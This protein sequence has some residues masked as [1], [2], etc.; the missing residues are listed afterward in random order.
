[1]FLVLLLAP[2]L[3]PPVAVRDIPANPGLGFHWPYLLVTPSQPVRP[4]IRLMG[5]KAIVRSSSQ[6]GFQQLRLPYLVP[7]FPRPRSQWK[8]YT[9]ALDHDSLEW[10]EPGM[11]RIDLQLIA[12]VEDARRRLA[13]EGNATEKKIFLWGSSA[14]GSFTIRFTLPHPERVQAASVGGCAV[15]AIPLHKIHG[16]AARYPIGTADLKQLTGKK[17]N[18]KAFRRVPI[19]IFRGAADDNDEVA[20]DDGYDAADRDFINRE[21]GRT[22]ADRAVFRDSSSLPAC[23]TGGENESEIPGRAGPKSEMAATDPL[24]RSQRTIPKNC[25]RTARRSS[26]EAS[27]RSRLVPFVVVTSLPSASVIR[28]LG[29]AREQIRF[30]VKWESGEVL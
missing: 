8:Y 29:T 6:P 10:R 26:S 27:M 23:S 24:K 18:A 25:S 15:P 19:Q 2:G 20:F 9:H 30:C 5:H 7:A 14:A 13:A 16:R 11:E 1:L 3:R 12:M 22:A 4:T 28:P 17:F 21:F